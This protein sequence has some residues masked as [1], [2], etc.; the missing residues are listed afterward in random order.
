MYRTIVVAILTMA[1]CGT[2]PANDESSNPASQSGQNLD[3][4][5]TDGSQSANQASPED[6]LDQDRDGLTLSQE[7][8][9]GTDDTMI[10]SDLDGLGD[11][12]EVMTYMTDPANPDTDHD[13]LSDFEEVLEYGTDPRSGD[14]DFDGL[15]DFDEIFLHGT[16]PTSLDSD[17]DSLEDGLEISIGTDPNLVD[18][19]G[20]G[21]SDFD[22]VRLNTDPIDSTDPSTF[23]AG[24]WFSFLS[25]TETDALRLM[26]SAASLR[27]AQAGALCR[28]E[29]STDLSG[30]GVF[31][32][33]AT[34][35]ILYGC[36][37]LAYELAIEGFEEALLELLDQIG[38]VMTTANRTEVAVYMHD[39][40]D[41]DDGCVLINCTWVS[42]L[43][44]WS[45]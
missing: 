44:A 28:L 30:R 15:T 4:P 23:V 5:A 32:G 6:V 16:D 27:A 21:F 40:F 7:L 10:D 35:G 19:D 24:D 37:R 38:Y 45:P 41:R 14:S 11:Y 26:D 43:C 29:R 31:G 2:L 18:T 17:G 13:G 9:Y 42:T 8:L 36:K 12:G 3:L 1:G 33:G 22:E 25:P 34:E 39:R 20:D